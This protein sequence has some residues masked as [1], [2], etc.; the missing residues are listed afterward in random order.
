MIKDG[1]GESRE[2]EGALKS[3]GKETICG[4]VSLLGDGLW[5]KESHGC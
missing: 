5:T 4:E 2:C 3:F 1:F